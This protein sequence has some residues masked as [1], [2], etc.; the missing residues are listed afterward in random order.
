MVREGMMLSERYEIIS[1]IGTGGMSDVYKAKDYKLNRFVAVKVL[2]AEYAENRNFVAKFRVEAQSAAAL[3]HPNIV[4]VYDVGDEQGINYIVMEL[5]EGITLKHYIEK[6]L[7]L[8]FKEAISIAIQVSMGLETAHENH[9]IHRDVKPQNIIISKEGKVKV[10]DF[11]IARAATSDTITSNVM[12]SVHYTS[13]EQARGGYSDEKSDIYSL[14]IVLFEMLTGRVPF[15]G[16]TA[17][18]IAIKQIQ[19]PMPNPRKYVD[20]IPVSVE[21]IIY[22]CCEKNADRRYSSMKDLIAD[23]KQS[24]ITPNDNFVRMIPMG[25]FNG[26]TKLVSDNDVKTIKDQTGTID[27]DDEVLKAYDS[28]RRRRRPVEEND[29]WDEDDE[30]E[31]EIRRVRTRR[32]ASM[33]EEDDRPVRKRTSS[34]SSKNKK[35]GKRRRDEADV[36]RRSGTKPSTRRKSSMYDDDEDDEDMNPAMQKLMAVLAVFV[37]VMIVVVLIVIAQKLVKS[38]LSS[39]K[40]STEAEA[41]T[42]SGNGIK[43]GNITGMTFAEARNELQDLGLTVQ[44]SQV[45][46]SADQKNKVISMTDGDGNK[47]SDG[48]SV[49]EG[50]T[51]ILQIG[52]GQNGEAEVP[53][54]TGKEKALANTTITAAGFTMELASTSA[55][56]GT[57]VSQTPK[58]GEKAATGSVITVTLSPSTA[59]TPSEENNEKQTDA[60][61]TTATTRTVPNIVGMTETAA[62]TALTASGLSFESITEEYSSTV[63]A[64]VVISQSPQAGTTAADGSGVNF[65]ISLGQESVTYGGTFSISAPPNYVAGTSAELVVTTAGGQVL[66]STNVT[67]FPAT[68][69]VAGASVQNGTLTVTYKKSTTVEYQDDDGNIVSKDNQQTTAVYQNLSFTKE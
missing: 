49:A 23:L 33:Y 57:V 22:K 46:S 44:S 59:E 60:A 30:D 38:H 13:P 62:K 18:G 37:A 15:D 63:A 56:S 5:V 24:L 67:S 35:N 14:G 2:K 11:G 12:G 31:E 54:V 19:E 1:K 69:S 26:A 21:H 7:R 43:L 42:E 8:S 34:S 6:K 32:R 45:A 9:V 47:V 40:V 28:S 20:D 55:T 39:D 52:S 48:D 64:G 36:R 61:P 27:L 68:I 16:D 65:V 17:V 29:D 53:D 41:A 25:G 51:I 66:T 10:T 4:N 3:M 58:A 50:S